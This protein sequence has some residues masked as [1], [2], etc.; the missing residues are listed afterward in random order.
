VAQEG[1]KVM[2][3]VEVDIESIRMLR[4]CDRSEAL[5]RYEDW[6]NRQRKTDRRLHANLIAR[7]GRFRRR[8]NEND[9][10]QPVRCD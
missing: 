9:A 6:R 4:G 8:K 3:L 10:V 5:R 2:K 7:I 1:D